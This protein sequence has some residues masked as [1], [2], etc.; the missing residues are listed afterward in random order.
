[1]ALKLPTALPTALPFS[2]SAALAVRTWP[3]ELRDTLF[4][5]A[6]VGWIVLLQS[7]HQP[8]WASALALLLLLGRAALAW[9]GRPLPGR[10]V[11]LALLLLVLA[12]TWMHHG[13]LWGAVAGSTL[14][15]LLLALKTLELRARRDALVIFFL[16]F[17]TLLTLLL[18]S[19][20]LLTALGIV[21]ALL[22][23][24][25]GLVLAHLPLGRPPL[26]L[27]LRQAGTLVLFGAPLMLLLFVLFP[28][29]GPLWHIPTDAQMGRSGLSGQM[30]VG[31]IAR[32]ALDPSVALRV[33]FLDGSRPP[34]DQL[35]F[36][37]PVLSRF[38][39]QQW[40]PQYSEHSLAEH[41]S[42]AMQTQLLAVGTPLR[43]RLTMEPSHQPWV[44]TLQTTPELPPIG[45]QNAQLTPDLQWILPRPLTEL[46]RFE[47]VAWPE[48]RHSPL[49]PGA[50]LAANLQLPPGFNPRTQQLAAELRQQLGAQA[51]AT[52]LIEAV[53]LRLRTGGYQYT[54]EPGVF[55]R[56]SADEFWFD[57]RQG[58]CEHIASA[59]VLLMR[60]LGIPARIVTGYHG[61][62]L[63]PIDGFW[64]VRQSDAHAWA[65]VWLDAQG[66]TRIDPTAHVAPARTTDL[67]RLLPPPGP[68]AAALIQL[69]PDLLAQMRA[70][71]EASNNRWNQ[72][73]LNYGQNRQLELLRQ[74]GFTAPN[75]QQLLYLLVGLLSLA[76]LAAVAWLHWVRP[77]PD[78]WLRLLQGARAAVAQAG[79]VVPAPATPRQLAAALPALACP[80]ETA[81]A[82]SEWLLRLET[83]RYDPSQR[84][85]LA[86]LRRQWRKLPPL[87]RPLPHPSPRT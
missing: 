15:V 5:L 2:L 21:P 17:F 23:L 60:E 83:Q 46:T 58:F 61:G 80:A 50:T 48:L 8:L 42:A 79:A 38:D 57:R 74:L 7:A 85:D 34:E 31:Q 49:R 11:M 10:A 37:G 55:G 27:A 78:P 16:G 13:R 69:D 76:T 53:L 56:H 20:A 52:Q 12:G 25:S 62:E 24:L 19:Q 71:W 40:L 32:L 87:P 43:Y 26:R 28:R 47:A 6:V 70:I 73:V 75:W 1:M 29:F 22:G 33:E 14:V 35:Y 36:R 59:F 44:L 63:N 68:F 4:L 67:E 84:L 41:T 86:V 3:R 51:S 82:W 18:H 81:A 66:W 72:W 9:Q 45:T 54:L 65:E 30:Q 77:R 39:G 64:T